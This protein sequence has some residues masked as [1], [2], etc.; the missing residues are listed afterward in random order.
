M[1]E[2]LKKGLNYTLSVVVGVGL[3]GGGAL[4]CGLARHLCPHRRSGSCGYCRGGRRCASH[5][6]CVDSLLGSHLAFVRDYSLFEQH[7][8]GAAEWVCSDLSDPYAL[9]RGENRSGH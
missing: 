8:R 5:N 4:L 9:L 6:R 2:P 3:L 7:H 1:K